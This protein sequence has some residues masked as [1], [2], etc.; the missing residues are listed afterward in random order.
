MIE[1]TWTVVSRA[2]YTVNERG[3]C[4]ALK[5]YPGYAGRWAAK[6]AVFKVLG[7]GWS[8]GIQWTDVEVINEPGG[9]AA[10][11]SLGQ[12]MGDRDRTWNRRGPYLHLALSESRREL[13]PLL[14]L[15]QPG[16]AP[17][18]IAG[19]SSTQPDDPP[20]QCRP[21]RG[22]PTDRVWIRVFPV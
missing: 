13:C 12:G 14:G 17:S 1:E 20:R 9:E 2:V 5:S 7:T 4:Q 19:H 15:S 10:H 18:L 22:S 6:E 3:Y 11:S 21:V 8:R 16:W